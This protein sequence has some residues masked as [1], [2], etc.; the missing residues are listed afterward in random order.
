MSNEVPIACDL[1]AISDDELESHR[2][3]GEAVLASIQEVREVADGYALRLPPDTT[4]IQQTGAFIAR[5]RLCCPFFEFNLTIQAVH[6]P[7]W[8]TLTGAE[9]VK[10]YIETALLP[11]LKVGVTNQ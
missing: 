2:E 1:S 8:L 5:E 7:V 3:N 4:I 11:Q 6:D 9:G 10:Q